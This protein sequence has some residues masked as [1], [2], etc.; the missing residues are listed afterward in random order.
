MARK[1][2][3]V[4][5]GLTVVLC[6]SVPAL[7]HVTTGDVAG[8]WKGTAETPM[9]PMENTITIRAGAP[10]AGNVKVGGDFPFEAQI[11]KAKLEGNKISFEITMQYGK[12]SYDGTVSGDEMQLNVTGIAG[13]KMI[14]IAK[15][16]K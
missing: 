8:T 2:P 14:L 5:L 3:L 16:Q 9:G 4:V 7:A 13:A 11:E 12:V 1:L 15:R 10:F 6:C